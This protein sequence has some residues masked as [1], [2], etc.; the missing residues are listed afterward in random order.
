V[1][2][3]YLCHKLIAYVTEKSQGSFN[4]LLIWSIIAV[5]SYIFFAGYISYSSNPSVTDMYIK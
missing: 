1:P 2:H 4:P 3:A 5:A